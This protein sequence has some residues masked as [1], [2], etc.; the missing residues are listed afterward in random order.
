MAIQLKAN[1]D[2]QGG[3]VQVNSMDVI[4]FDQ[5]GNVVITGTLSA[6]GGIGNSGANGAVDSVNGKTGTVVL[7]KADIGLS[8]VDNTSDINKPISRATQLALDAKQAVLQSG[9][10]IKTVNGQSMLGSGNIVVSGVSD[11]ITGNFEVTGEINANSVH[12]TNAITSENITASGH[13]S[14]ATLGAGSI[15][16]GN[17]T[18]SGVISAVDFNST[19][20]ARLKTDVQD[21]DGLELIKKIRPVAFKWQESGSQSYGVLAQ[22]LEK[23]MPELVNVKEDGTYGVSYIPMIAMLVDAVQQ[24]S[25]K[26]EQNN[27]RV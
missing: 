19:S 6:N 9:T 1:L 12:A 14:C 5:D 23:V 16:T 3:A 10:N 2:G 25:S 22:E 21:I 7:S 8:N 26:L 24:L 18:S 15:N 4:T 17:I 11:T 20:D 13:V 27:G